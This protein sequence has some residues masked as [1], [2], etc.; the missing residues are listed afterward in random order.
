MQLNFSQQMR[1][2]QQMKLAPRM[3]QSM[4]ILQ[5]PYLELQER[6][7][8]ELEENVVL[9]A[10]GLKSEKTDSEIQREIQK[11]HEE[12]TEKPLDQ[13]E[14]IVDNEHGN[15]AD[16]ERLMEMSADW[17]DD[18]FAGENR[19]SSNRM[20]DD[21]ERYDDL[22]S[23]VESSPQTL[24]DAL[25]EQFAYVDGTPQ[26]IDFGK[27]LILNLDEN[28]RLQS[29]LPE[30]VQV[31][32]GKISFE[33]AQYVL[34]AIQKLEPSGVGA[35]DLKECLL[36][37]LTDD[38]IYKDVIATLIIDHIDDL[39]NNRLPLIAKKTGFS[40][41]E[42]KEAMEEMR[43]L[44]PFPGRRFQ[45]RQVHNVT[46]DVIV[47]KDDNGQW[48]VRVIDEYI[49]SLRIS[50]KYREML[51]N[52]VDQK[53]KEYIKKK[54]DSAKW[55]IE[56]IEQ[57]YT[58]LRRVAQAIVDHQSAFLEHGPDQIQPLK[59]QQ[60][61]DQVGVHVTTVSRA[62]DDKWIQSSRGVIPLKRFFGG[63]TKTATGE[64]VAWDIVR[65]KLQ[66]LIDGENK[67]N[68]YSDDEIVTEMGKLGYTL[69]RR[70]VTKYRKK[71]NIPTSRQRKQY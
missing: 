10:E 63:G 26:Q 5:L 61:A 44:D 42:I 71:M 33:D 32:G 64:D 3:I 21:Q 20:S 27:Y 22:M 36:L 4:E 51:R 47:E 25:I 28:G 15:D 30:I 38:M 69:A 39:G 34:R 6:I 59:M 58:T 24:H 45:A 67:D 7:E 54:I 55:L 35:R 65:I 68:P 17:P 60:I 56:S 46:P 13:R 49:P 37:Q 70:T 43:G 29:S 62:V 57:R 66:E 18:N 48:K 2:S 11:A 9:I 23:N 52:G 31:Y 16:F 8:Q 40:I 14:L 41:D 1:M 19:P 50:K 53:T 12:A